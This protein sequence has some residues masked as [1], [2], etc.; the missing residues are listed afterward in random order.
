MAPKKAPSK[1]AG[2]KKSVKKA[3]GDSPKPSPDKKDS[4]P[5]KA[6]GGEKVKLIFV[7]DPDGPCPVQEEMK[8]NKNLRVPL[9]APLADSAD[10]IAAQLGVG[11]LDGIT[12]FQTKGKF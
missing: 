8:D 6:A 3:D 11:S 5:K 10:K 7:G 4:A 9:D 12:L 2:A 1:K